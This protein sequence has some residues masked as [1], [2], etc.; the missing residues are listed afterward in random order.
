M[1]PYT[2]VL[3][4]RLL[5]HF[6]IKCQLLFR[7]DWELWLVPLKSITCVYTGNNMLIFRYNVDYPI[8]DTCC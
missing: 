1:F 7:G 6:R 2:E 4:N 8:G 5:G 3:I